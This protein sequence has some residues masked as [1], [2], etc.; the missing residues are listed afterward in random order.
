[1]NL[2]RCSKLELKIKTKNLI[3]RWYLESYKKL[4]DNKDIDHLYLD[5][6]KI[7]NKD[8]KEYIKLFSFLN[9]K[10]D[11]LNKTTT[12]NLIE[13][14]SSPHNYYPI[15]KYIDMNEIPFMKTYYKKTI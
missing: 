4:N 12:E 11:F 6:E 14:K 13:F 7:I 5:F 15:K 10:D 8:K 3:V 9:L 2:E 1:M